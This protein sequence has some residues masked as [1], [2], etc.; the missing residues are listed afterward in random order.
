MQGLKFNTNIARFLYYS[1]TLVLLKHVALS[2]NVM[3]KAD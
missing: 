2:R 3:T 1:S